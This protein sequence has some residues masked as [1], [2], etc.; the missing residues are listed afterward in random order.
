MTASRR[1]IV[2]ESNGEGDPLYQRLINHDLHLDMLKVT[3]LPYFALNIDLPQAISDYLHDSI[4]K[5]ESIRFH[6]IN[7][8]YHDSR[9][10]LP[11]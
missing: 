10:R 2:L 6:A 7:E 1:M 5:I 8:V 3:R 11:Q 9:H 4:M